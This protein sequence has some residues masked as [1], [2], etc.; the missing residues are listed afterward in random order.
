[1]PDWRKQIL[2]EFTAG[3]RPITAVADPDGLLAGNQAFA[4]IAANS[5]TGVAGQLHYVVNASGGVSVE[6]DTD[7]NGAANFS[8][9]VDG[10]SSLVSGDFIL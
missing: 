9:S 3:V 2:Q 8:I 10:V 5:F 6:G 4:F 1:M 7:G